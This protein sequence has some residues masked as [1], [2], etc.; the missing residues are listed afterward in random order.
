MMSNSEKDTTVNT[1][2]SDFW[3]SES[4]YAERVNCDGFSWFDVENI[5]LDY[6]YWTQSLDIFQDW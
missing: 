6:V 4:K 2:K 5:L 1:V 3:G